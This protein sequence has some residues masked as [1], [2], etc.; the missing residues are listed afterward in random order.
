[1]G[2]VCAALSAGDAESDAASVLPLLLRGG[3]KGQA[4]LKPPLPWAKKARNAL[5]SPCGLSKI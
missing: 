2:L 4:A 1:M 5:S 3:G